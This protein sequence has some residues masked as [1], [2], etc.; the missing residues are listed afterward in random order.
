MM[1]PRLR[2]HSLVNS[3]NPM[4]AAVGPGPMGQVN[5]QPGFRGPSGSYGPN[6]GTPPMVNGRRMTSNPVRLHGRLELTSRWRRQCIE[7][8]RHHLGTRTNHQASLMATCPPTQTNLL[9][10]LD[11]RRRL[12]PCLTTLGRRV[13]SDS[14]L[15]KHHR[16]H[17]PNR[18]FRATACRF[19]PFPRTLGICSFL[20]VWFTRV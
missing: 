12:Q 4:M 8:N 13:P 19:L 3:T 7:R 17:S 10:P 9:L 11:H 16:L 6:G 18:L 2:K 5:G 14:T 20:V 1:P 15:H